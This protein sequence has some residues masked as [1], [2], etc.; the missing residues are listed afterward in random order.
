MLFNVLEQ[1]NQSWDRYALV[2]KGP[3]YS[4]AEIL[5]G[6]LSENEAG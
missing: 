5:S 4:R 3:D 2:S 1:N 6:W